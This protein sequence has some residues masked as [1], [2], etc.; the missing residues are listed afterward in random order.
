MR[1]Q[2]SERWAARPLSTHRT[3]RMRNSDRELAGVVG[4]LGRIGVSAVGRPRAQNASAHNNS[5]PD[6]DLLVEL[7]DMLIEHA[8]AP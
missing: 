7:V 2:F 6:G 1:P 4:Y 3:N 8:D 5:R